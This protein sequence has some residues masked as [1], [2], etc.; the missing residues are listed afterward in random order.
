M[1]GHS[2][3][4][5]SLD[6]TPAINSR[7]RFAVFFRSFLVSYGKRTHARVTQSSSTLTHTHVRADKHRGR[8]SSQTDG[9][10]QTHSIDQGSND[11]GRRKGDSERG[12]SCFTER[13]RRAMKKGRRK[14]H[15]KNGGRP[16]RRKE[17]QI[18]SQKGEMME[19][20]NIYCSE[21]HECNACSNVDCK[22]ST[23]K[24]ERCIE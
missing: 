14:Q 17:P 23:K 12:C 4:S 16:Q 20:D 9:D 8:K 19:Y 3:P 22:R 1:Q 7:V 5:L 13:H 11:E 21:V 15:T 24:R 10:G 2:P 18:Q 6:P